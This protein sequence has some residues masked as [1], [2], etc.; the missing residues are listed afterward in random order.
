MFAVGQKVSGL[1]YFTVTKG[2]GWENATIVG[3]ERQYDLRRILWRVRYESDG[4]T[5][6]M[7][8]DD[9]ELPQE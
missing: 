3:F 7:L 9:L 5:E 6:L 2:G 8:E 1:R 4:F